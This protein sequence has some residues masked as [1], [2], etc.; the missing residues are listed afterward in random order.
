MARYCFTLAGRTGY[1][2]C[3]LLASLRVKVGGENAVKSAVITLFLGSI[4]PC[5]LDFA[6]KDP[7]LA[8]WVLN[9]M[10]SEQFFDEIVEVVAV[11]RRGIKRVSR[12][13]FAE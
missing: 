1:K 13:N 12:L 8:G 3:E 11:Y 7:W 10:D 6:G 9:I 5:W 4:T 2:F